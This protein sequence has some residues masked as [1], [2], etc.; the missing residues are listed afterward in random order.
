MLCLPRADSHI[1]TLTLTV[2]CILLLYTMYADQ[3]HGEVHNMEHLVTMQCFERKLP[4]GC[5]FIHTSHPNTV[6]EHLHLLVTAFP[7]GR[8][9]RPPWIRL[10]QQMLD[11]IGNLEASLIP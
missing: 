2:F 11:Y 1:T 9:M 5:H 8:E 7:N 6:A 3:P 10:R 4:G